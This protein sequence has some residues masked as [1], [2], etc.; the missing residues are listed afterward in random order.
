M[1]LATAQ[2]EAEVR[3]DAALVASLIATQVPEAAGLCLGARFEGKDAIV[4]RLGD[5]WAVRL[6]RRQ[7]AADRDVT[8]VDWLPRI[9]TFGR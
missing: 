3:V 8:A 6:P 5:A 9:S 2:T 4:W 7:L 1:T